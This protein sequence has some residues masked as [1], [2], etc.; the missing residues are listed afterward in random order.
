MVALCCYKSDKKTPDN[1]RWPLDRGGPQRIRAKMSGLVQVAICGLSDSIAAGPD[2]TERLKGFFTS[3]RTCLMSWSSVY[4]SFNVHPPG[5]AME[6]ARLAGLCERAASL[7]KLPPERGAA[8][9][10]SGSKHPEGLAP[11]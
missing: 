5:L 10:T 11:S 2:E 8:S 1:L 3:I 6:T 9:G 4:E 7:G